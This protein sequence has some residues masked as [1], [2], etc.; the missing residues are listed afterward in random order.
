[1]DGTLGR[2]LSGLSY[3]VILITS[4]QT[5]GAFALM[6]PKVAAALMII[7]A[8]ITAF[9]ERVSGGK[10]TVTVQQARAN[11]IAGTAK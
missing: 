10:S 3:V 11:E 4:L 6:P 9:S 8:S 1:M 2:I 5:A 7:A